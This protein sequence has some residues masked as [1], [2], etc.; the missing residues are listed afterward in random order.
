MLRFVLQIATYTIK[1]KGL[2]KEFEK[3]FMI[4]LVFSQNN[5]EILMIIPNFSDDKN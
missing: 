1:L 5:S 3:V 2:P 4:M